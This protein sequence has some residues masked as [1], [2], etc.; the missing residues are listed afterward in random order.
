MT[1]R[2]KDYITYVAVGLFVF[3]IV[4]EVLLVTW[5]PRRLHSSILWQDQVVCE[6]MIELEDLL[7]AYMIDIKPRFRNISGEIEL[8]QSCLN[9]I[10][11]YLR[12]HK[13]DL[14]RDHIDEIS[15]RLRYFE[16]IYQNKIRQGIS[17]VRIESMNSSSFIEKLRSTS[18]PGRASA[19]TETTSA[20]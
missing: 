8:V 18:S 5:L 11:G 15:A 16:G 7:R 6:E 14:S 2:R 10:A 4:F 1:L 12:E 20:R 17:F 19:E 3:V 13:D 9:E